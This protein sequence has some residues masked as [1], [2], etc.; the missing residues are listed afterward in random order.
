MNFLLWPLLWFGLP[1]Q[2]LIHSDR[3]AIA[4]LP[5]RSTIM[6]DFIGRTHAAACIYQSPAVITMSYCHILILLW[7]V[8]RH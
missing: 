7:Q 3:F 5:Q 8:L 1:G 2:L 6:A 4:R